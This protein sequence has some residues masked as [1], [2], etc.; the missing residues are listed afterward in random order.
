MVTLKNYFAMTV[1]LPLALVFTPVYASEQNDAWTQVKGIAKFVAEHPAQT[2]KI[3]STVAAKVAGAAL[4][5]T[6]L[7]YYAIKGFSVMAEKINASTIGHKLQVL[8]KPTKK[9][10]ILASLALLAYEC[11]RSLC[12]TLGQSAI[13]HEQQAK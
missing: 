7:A 3:C 12:E 6:V 2:V 4:A 13:N 8:A 1:L 9:I 11:S 5:T 10:V